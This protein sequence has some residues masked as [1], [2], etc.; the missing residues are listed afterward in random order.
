MPIHLTPIYEE[1]DLFKC[2]DSWKY[3]FRLVIL[4]AAFFFDFVADFLSTIMKGISKNGVP[5]YH[6]TPQ[7]G[8]SYLIRLFCLPLS[9]QHFSI[10]WMYPIEQNS[11][12]WKTGTVI[13]MYS[14]FVAIKEMKIH[15]VILSSHGSFFNNQQKIHYTLSDRI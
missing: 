12:F 5:A 1:Y 4:L 8:S 7:G 3:P 6:Y 14:C 11:I 10:T 9:I 2:P 15:C 13:P